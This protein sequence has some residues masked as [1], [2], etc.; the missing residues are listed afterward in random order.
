MSSR[1]PPA[2]RADSPP[3]G[4]LQF[5]QG[6]AIDGLEFQWQV[7]M[8]EQKSSTKKQR[9]IGHEQ[10][11]IP[12][13]PV[14]PPEVRCFRMFGWYVLGVQIPP[15]KVFGSIGYMPRSPMT[16]IFEGQ[17]TQNKAEIPIKTRVIWL[18]GI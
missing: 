16:S 2:D 10:H 3:P 6:P 14:I 11:L 18:L 13:L 15:H 17:P 7:A 9:R 4:L 12:R 8:N 1:M 5:R